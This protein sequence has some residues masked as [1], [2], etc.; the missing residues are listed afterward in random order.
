MRLETLPRSGRQWGTGRSR[1]SAK[2]RRSRR[3]VS[4]IIAVILL[5]AITVVLAAVLY[6]LLTGLTHGPS[7]T[8]IGG[9]FS[10]DRPSGS[11]CTKGG[12]TFAANGCLTGDYEYTLTVESSSITFANIEF[13][14]KTSGG[15]ILSLGAGVG[16]FSILNSGGAV[17]AQGTGNGVT[18]NAVMAMNAPLAHFGASPTCNGAACTTST[19]F[20]SIYQIV[21]DMGTNNPA[22]QGYTFVGIGIGSY[23]GTTTP[24]ALP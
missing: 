8:G 22:A 5:V 10:A 17:A 16:G 24:L 6:L 9:A 2:G 1:R 7:S 20:T 3:G 12:E 21:I 4:D 15:T 14:V 11:Q 19:P 23:S 13:Q 18:A